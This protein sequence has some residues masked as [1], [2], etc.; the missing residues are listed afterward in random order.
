MSKH[1]KGPFTAFIWDK[2]KPHEIT[3]G[4]SQAEGG[5]DHVVTGEFKGGMADAQLL[6]A[7]PDMLEALHNVRLTM[8][9]EHNFVMLEAM[10]KQVM[11]AIAKAEGR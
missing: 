5:G 2:T 8:G 11:T 6:A 9:Q 1:T 7:A 10:L 3:I 4:A